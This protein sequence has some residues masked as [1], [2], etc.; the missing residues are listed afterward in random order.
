MTFYKQLL[1]D[2][3]NEIPIYI[4]N[5]WA[6]SEALTSLFSN[7][8]LRKKLS[9]RDVIFQGQPLC[10]LLLVVCHFLYLSPTEALVPLPIFHHVS[11][12]VSSLIDL[13]FFMQII[14]G[15]YGLFLLH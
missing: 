11:Q 12:P 7:A 3:V 15:N 8:C 4:D 13:T 14:N 5:A 6:K 10:L 1:V 9:V 2:D